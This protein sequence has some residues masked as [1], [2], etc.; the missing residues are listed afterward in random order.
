LTG[1]QRRIQGNFLG[2]YAQQ[3]LGGQWL[4][5]NRITADARIAAGRLQQP[6]DH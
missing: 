4:G 1:V 2:D 3:A 6:A 5:G